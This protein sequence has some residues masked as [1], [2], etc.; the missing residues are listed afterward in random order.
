MPDLLKDYVVYHKPSGT[1]RLYRKLTE[2]QI[3][4]YRGHGEIIPS[5]SLSKV[6]NYPIGLWKIR[7]TK[8]YIS[9]WDKLKLFIKGL[10]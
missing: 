3:E 4:V 10:F 1:V 7:G 6:K 5:P 9:L 8:I 2:A